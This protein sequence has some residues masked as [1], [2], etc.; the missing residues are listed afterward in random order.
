M[1]CS[2]QNITPLVGNSINKVL[3]LSLPNLSDKLSQGRNLNALPQKSSHLKFYMI[4]HISV[5]HLH[6]YHIACPMYYSRYF[7]HVGSGIPYVFLD[8]SR[9][10]RRDT[11]NDIYGM[12]R[13]GHDLPIKKAAGR[14]AGL[15]F[16]P[17]VP[18]LLL[19]FRELS[20]RNCVGCR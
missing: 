12:Y 19:S 3:P 17:H 8:K 20:Y 11:R 1:K 7:R 18:V 13:D 2:R 9:Q 5:I 14:T 6:S 4:L 16:H 10:K 15:P